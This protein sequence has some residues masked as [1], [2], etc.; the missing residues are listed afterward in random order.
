MQKLVKF[1]RTWLIKRAFYRSFH[2][3]KVDNTRS[4]ELLLNKYYTMTYTCKKWKITLKVMS[5]VQ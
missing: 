5:D 2:G 3:C 1:I 4:P